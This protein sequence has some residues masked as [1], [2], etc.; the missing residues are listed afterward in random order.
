MGGECCER[1][2]R[3]YQGPVGPKGDKGDRGEQGLPG[4]PGLTG[5][6][7]PMGPQG[8][9]GDPGVDG[10]VGPAGPAGPAGPPGA[11]GSNGTN[12]VDGAP[13]PQ[14]DS[15]ADGADG[16]VLL[17]AN[18]TEYESGDADL[19]FPISTSMFANDGDGLRVSAI[20]TAVTTSLGNLQ[21]TNVNGS[22]A[23]TDTLINHA[24]SAL[25]NTLVKLEMFLIKSG[26]TMVGHYTLLGTPDTI[27]HGT[28]T[29][30]NFF[31]SPTT[32]LKFKTTGVAGDSTIDDILVEYLKK[33]I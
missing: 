14:G 13:G 27:V 25:S 6:M 15:G 22:P 10:A 30:T 3:G 2:P 7:G 8:P 1:G 5:P 31:D 29:C 9:Q 28:F 11:A 24:F 16:I 33:K 17:V 18:M 20:V 26:T 21:V 4:L 23:T 19:S 12:G 32:N